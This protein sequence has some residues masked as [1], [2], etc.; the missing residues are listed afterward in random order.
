MRAA[1][2]RTEPHGRVECAPTRLDAAHHA[3]ALFTGALPPT[4]AVCYNDAVALGLMLGLRRHG[5]EPGRDF[6]LTGF[7]GIAEA[8]LGTPPLT[9]LSAAPRERGRQA[10]ELVLQ[11]LQQPRAAGR[12]VLAPVELVV[13]ESSCPPIA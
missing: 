1:G 8:A 4:A 12:Q 9:T 5:L 10:A 2:L 6:A 11:R 13:R 3:P 7:D